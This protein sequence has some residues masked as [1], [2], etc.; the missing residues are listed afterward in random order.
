MPANQLFLTTLCW[1]HGSTTGHRRTG[2]ARVPVDVATSIFRHQL[3]KKR[4]PDLGHVQRIIAAY[5]F[6]RPGK[7]A[8]E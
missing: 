8:N 7:A 4:S 2:K 6:V 1:S 5:A 3:H